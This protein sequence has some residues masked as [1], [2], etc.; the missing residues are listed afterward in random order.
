MYIITTYKANIIKSHD[1]PIII[2][3]RSYDRKLQR[4]RGKTYKKTTKHFLFLR[5]LNS[6]SLLNPSVDVA[7]YLDR[8]LPMN[9]CFWRKEHVDILLHDT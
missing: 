5:Y 9:I 2:L 3:E 7:G 4:Q 6:T 8:L 1:S